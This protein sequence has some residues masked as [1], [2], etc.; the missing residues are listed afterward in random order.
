VTNYEIQYEGKKVQADNI[1]FSD[2]KITRYVHQFCACRLSRGLDTG[3]VRDQ[4]FLLLTAVIPFFLKN[5]QPM[6][7]PN[8]WPYC[9]KPKEEAGEFEELDLTS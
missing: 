6:K 3:T 5:K 8:Y 7:D 1:L 9:R 2:D 4:K